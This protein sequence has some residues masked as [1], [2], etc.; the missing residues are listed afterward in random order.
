MNANAIF[1]YKIIINV[2]HSN[3]MCMRKRQFSEM[4]FAVCKF[5]STISL[6]RMC[7]IRDITGKM[8]ECDQCDQ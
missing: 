2:F 7:K 4:H 8:A 6:M 1:V 5:Y 3:S